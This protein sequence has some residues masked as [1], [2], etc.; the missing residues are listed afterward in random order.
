MERKKWLETFMWLVNKGATRIEYRKHLRLF[1]GALRRH[2][3][4]LVAYRQ[5][6][7]DIRADEEKQDAMRE[8]MATA[9][10]VKEANRLLELEKQM[11]LEE[12]ERWEDDGGRPDVDSGEGDGGDEDNKE[13]MGPREDNIVY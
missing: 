8:R 6:L 9:R 13:T 12:K 5:E 1:P 10:A 11:L 4:K 3:S 7:R 2:L